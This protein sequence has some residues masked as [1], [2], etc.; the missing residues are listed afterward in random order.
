MLNA[1]AATSVLV[2]GARGLARIIDSADGLSVWVEISPEVRSSEVVEQAAA[3]GVLIAPGEP[4][5]LTIGRN[6]AVRFNAGSARNIDHAAELGQTLANAIIRA[7]ESSAG[8]F[9]IP[10]T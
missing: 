6:D 3:L 10:H 8:S 2:S 4:F 1:E 9:L 7:A 5:Y